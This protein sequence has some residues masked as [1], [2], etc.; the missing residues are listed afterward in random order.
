M[1]PLPSFSNLLFVTYHIPNSEDT[2]GPD[3]APSVRVHELVKLLEPGS[4]S[5]LCRAP[6]G[7]HWCLLPQTILFPVYL[8]KIVPIAVSLKIKV[9]LNGGIRYLQIGCLEY[10][11]NLQTE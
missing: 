4:I 7:P 1:G 6:Y 3:G 2:V 10:L 11:H 8:G 9:V 5:L